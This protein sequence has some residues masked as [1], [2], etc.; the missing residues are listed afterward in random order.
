MKNVN[1]V[2][3]VVFNISQQ[4]NPG[5]ICGSQQCKGITITS[6]FSLVSVNQNHQMRGNSK[7]VQFNEGK[8]THV[9]ASQKHISKIKA[10]K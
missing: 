6:A 7:A 10:I 1:G 4:K 3:K 5:L 8:I 2:H 9:N